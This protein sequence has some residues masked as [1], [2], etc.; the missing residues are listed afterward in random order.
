MSVI[1]SVESRIQSAPASYSNQMLLNLESTWGKT[2]D[3][4]LKYATWLAT[5]G[6]LVTPVVKPMGTQP[7]AIRKDNLLHMFSMGFAFLDQKAANLF[8]FTFQV[9][10]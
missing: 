2:L 1:V 9:K 8:A 7:D 4:G 5:M 6:L 3:D 10:Q